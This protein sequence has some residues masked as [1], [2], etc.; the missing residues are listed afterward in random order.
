MLIHPTSDVNPFQP[1]L[2]SLDVLVLAH[3]QLREVPARVF[4]HLKLLTSLELEGNKISHIDIDAFSGLEGKQRSLLGIGAR[5]TRDKERKIFA[6]IMKQSD[7]VFHSLLFTK[8]LL[9]SI[10][11]FFLILSDDNLLSVWV[12]D[13]KQ[14]EHARENTQGESHRSFIFVLMAPVSKVSDIKESE[15]GIFVLISPGFLFLVF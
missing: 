8:V 3:N 5:S 11:L 9:I 4:G 6:R 15:I 13:E 12:L 10:S 1:G 14:A 2:R 7:Q